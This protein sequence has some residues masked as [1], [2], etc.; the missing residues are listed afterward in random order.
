MPITKKELKNLIDNEFILTKKTNI[1]SDGVNFL[2]RIPKKICE[3]IGINKGDK[4]AWFYHIKSNKL[5]IN[6]IKNETG[7]KENN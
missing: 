7:K 4:I 3:E 2:T 6:I 5:K 1:V